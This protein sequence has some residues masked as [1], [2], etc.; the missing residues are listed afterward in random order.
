MKLVTGA[1]RKLADRTKGIRGGGRV[2]G[3]GQKRAAACAWLETIQPD[4]GGKQ[5]MKE[6]PQSQEERD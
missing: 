5:D 1:Q 4:E 2:G 6:V 3:K